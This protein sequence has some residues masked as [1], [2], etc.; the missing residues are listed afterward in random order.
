MTIKNLNTGATIEVANTRLTREGH[1]VVNYKGK[2]PSPR[3]F[4]KYPMLKIVGHKED[5]TAIMALDFG[6]QVENTK[7]QPTPAP[8][9][10]AGDTTGDGSNTVED[11]DAGDATETDTTGETTGNESNSGDTTGDAGDATE[12]SETTVDGVGC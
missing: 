3:Y 6:W 12:A 11:G 4:K 8:D 7:T 2:D 1:I 5:G 9:G 10:T